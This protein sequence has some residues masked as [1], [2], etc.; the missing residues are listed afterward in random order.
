ML[1]RT[2]LTTNAVRG[3]TWDYENRLIKVVDKPSA[4]GEA[5]STTTY[6]YDALGRNI[7]RDINGAITRYVYNGN[8]IFL[9]FN[10]NNILRARY[11]HGDGVD[12]PYIM[13]RKGTSYQNN[14]Y[15][16]Q[17]FYYHRDRLGSITE[18]TN[19]V[20]DVVQRYVYDAF[21]KLKS[22]MMLVP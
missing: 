8:N 17:D 3:H 9:E 14:S 18:I 1:K 19:F 11:I 22:T 16:R 2:H 5:T 10:G 4:T 21:G 7:E 13:E 15:A 20:G 12:R 6:K